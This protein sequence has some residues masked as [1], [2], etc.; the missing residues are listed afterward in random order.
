[1]TNLAKISLRI[2]EFYLAVTTWCVQ[3]N[4]VKFSWYLL[5]AGL[6]CHWL[7]TT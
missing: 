3:Q 5:K 2:S 7:S 1:M 6:P 4:T